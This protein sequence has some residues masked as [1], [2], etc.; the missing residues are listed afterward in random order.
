M[1][2]NLILDSDDARVRENCRISE[3]LGKGVVENGQKQY[4]GDRR[5]FGGYFTGIGGY[6]FFANGGIDD[7]C[8]SKAYTLTSQATRPDQLPNAIVGPPDKEPELM[9]VIEEAIDIVNYI[10]YKLCSPF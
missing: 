5:W 8:G 4:V 3:P 6:Y 1:F 7:N 9:K 10:H 2:V